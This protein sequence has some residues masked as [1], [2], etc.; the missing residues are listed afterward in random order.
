MSE[1]QA[2]AFTP[3]G[4][5]P[6]TA[7][8]QLLAPVMADAEQMNG[9]RSG[10]MSGTRMPDHTPIVAH[11]KSTPVVVPRPLAASDNSPR[12]IIKA[13][14][15]KIAQLRTELRRMKALQKELAELERLVAAAKS[16]PV[17]VVRNL[18]HARHAR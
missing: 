14:K 18:D 17:A 4:I 5:V 10:A 13:A 2:Y 7:Q 12:G 3:D 9:T 6:I 1:G 16:K 15:A 8:G 11:A